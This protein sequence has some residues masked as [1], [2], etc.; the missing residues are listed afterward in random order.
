MLTEAVAERPDL[1]DR[2]VRRVIPAQQAGADL[3]DRKVI[4]DPQ[5]KTAL[6]A[7]TVLTAKPC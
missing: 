6:M 1:R 5:V 4:Q 2:K 3:R 7:L